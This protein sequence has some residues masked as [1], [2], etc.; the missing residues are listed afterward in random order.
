VKEEDARTASEREHARD[1]ERCPDHCRSGDDRDHRL[2]HATR[3]GTTEAIHG[4]RKDREDDMAVT[5]LTS[6]VAESL[7]ELR[8]TWPQ[9]AAL[10]HSVALDHLSSIV[11]RP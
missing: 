11:T 5:P 9:S 6:H 4:N 1:P 10:L 7:Q 2:G 3:G 8:F